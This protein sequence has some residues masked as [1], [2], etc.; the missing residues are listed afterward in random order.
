MGFSC[1]GC[2]SGIT[3]EPC[4]F[5]FALSQGLY[6][7][8]AQNLYIAK[9]C[10]VN[11]NLTKEICDDIINNKVLFVCFIKHRIFILFR[12][13]SSWSREKCLSCRLTME[14]CR[15][16]PAISLTSVRHSVNP[17]NMLIIKYLSRLCHLLCT[18]CLLGPGQIS[19]EEDFW[20]FGLALASF[21]TMEFSS[22]IPIGSMNLK[23]SI[24]SLSAFR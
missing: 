24:S 18:L 12:R 23:L 15:Y 21:S 14:F 13:N 16:I 11:F 4:L 6:V 8:I 9:V 3:V 20:L 2:L 7:I 17:C 1:R 5:F 10:N 22:S 19:T